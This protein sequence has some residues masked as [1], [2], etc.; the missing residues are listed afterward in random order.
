MEKI[1]ITGNG[2]LRGEVRVLPVPECSLPIIAASLLSAEPCRSAIFPACAISTPPQ[3]LTLL[4][5]QVERSGTDLAIDTSKVHSVYAP[6]ELVKTMRGAILLLGPLL[7][8]LARPMYRFPAAAPS[9]H[10]R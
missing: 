10:A 2:P 5:C 9:V 1:V 8:R 4:G 7:A 6:Y 3:L